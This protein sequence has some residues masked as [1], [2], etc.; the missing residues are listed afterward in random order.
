M[1]LIWYILVYSYIRYLW[2]VIMWVD[3]CVGGR[4]KENKI[5]IGFCMIWVKNE[6]DDCV[7]FF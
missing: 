6:I 3:I 5:D 7:G 2:I 1:L 4:W